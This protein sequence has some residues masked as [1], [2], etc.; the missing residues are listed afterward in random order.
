MIDV[1]FPIGLFNKWH[2][3]SQSSSDF[4]ASCLHWYILSQYLINNVK[5]FLHMIYMW[6]RFD[7]RF[8]AYIIALSSRVPSVLFG[9]LYTN[10]HHQRTTCLSHETLCNP[11]VCGMMKILIISDWPYNGQI[12][13]T[14]WS[15]ATIL[16]KSQRVYSWPTAH[17]VCCGRRP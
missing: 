2:L 6:K 1:I 4:S 7:I 9:G 13:V 16:L 14:K 5:Q 10:A 12:I 3:F 15:K 8:F 11:V 17:T